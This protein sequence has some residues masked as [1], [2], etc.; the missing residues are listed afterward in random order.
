MQPPP[1]ANCSEYLSCV[2]CLPV[3]DKFCQWCERPGLIGA[4]ICVD[5]GVNCLVPN[6]VTVLRTATCPT[7]A[8]TPPPTLMPT[9]FVRFTVRISDSLSEHR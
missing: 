4:G 7:G 5:E 1:G 9:P 2:Q 3:A 6:N 8:P